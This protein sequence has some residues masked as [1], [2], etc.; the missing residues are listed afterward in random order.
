M[1]LA[2]SALLWIS[3]NRKLRATLPRYKF[4][5]HAVTRFMPGEE[6]SDAVRA[7]RVLQGQSIKT[8]FT[9]LGENVADGEEARAVAREAWSRGE[10]RPDEGERER[11]HTRDNIVAPIRTAKQ[12]MASFSEQNS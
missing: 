12:A 4:V 1:N 7:A 10:G 3:E 8:I 6:L 5:R 9:R 11:V 2:R